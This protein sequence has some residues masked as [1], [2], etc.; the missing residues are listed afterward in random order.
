MLIAPL[1]LG[2]VPAPAPTLALPLNDGAQAEHLPAETRFVAHVDFRAVFESSLWKQGLGD[3]VR[4]ELSND[5]GF[6][7]MKTEL[8]LDPFED[9]HSVTVFGSS[10]DEDSVAVLVRGTKALEGALRRI[11]GMDGHT[12]FEVEGL[13]L[14]V[15][16]EGGDNTYLYAHDGGR[17]D[18]RTIVLSPNRTELLRTA[19]VLRGQRQSI[20]GARAAGGGAAALDLESPAGTILHVAFAGAIPG[21]DGDDPVSGVLRQARGGVFSLGES[22]GELALHLGILTDSEDQALEMADAVDGLKAL[23]NLLL[24]NADDV[25]PEARQLLRS[26]RVNSDD[27][28]VFVDF[29]FPIEKLFEMADE[30]GLLK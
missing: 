10:P 5:E 20:A 9:L 12:S 7:Q 22:R 23:G 18:E 29:S 1:L 8:G 17:S 26:F 27:N 14:H 19:L 30:N 28:K 3:M 6:Q 21:L 15:F 13:K 4:G 16:D 2:L 11:E 24:K 25:P